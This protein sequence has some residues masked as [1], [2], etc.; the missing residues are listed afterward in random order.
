LS[1]EDAP[2]T[3]ERKRKKPSPSH[4]IDLDQLEQMLGGAP[5]HPQEVSVESGSPEEGKEEMDAPLMT[6]PAGASHTIDVNEFARALEEESQAPIRSNSSSV[7]HDQGQ[8]LED[9]EVIEDSDDEELEPTRGDSDDEDDLSSP[10]LSLQSASLPSESVEIAECDPVLLSDPSAV[11]SEPLG[12]FSE[13]SGTASPNT[14][15]LKREVSPPQIEVSIAETSS[16]SSPSLSPHPSP[17]NPTPPLPE[18]SIALTEA[19]IAMATRKEEDV[20][21]GNGESQGQ[22]EETEREIPATSS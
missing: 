9:Q 13:S 17:S 12:G 18:P 7:G 20:K 15:E 22:G 3:T 8:V 21:P 4:K 11:P 10:S 5:L 2:S 1:S 14:S 6:P 19:E 16:P